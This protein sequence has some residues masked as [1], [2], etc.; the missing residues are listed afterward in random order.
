[1]YANVAS[2]AWFESGNPDGVGRPGVKPDQ[3]AN[4]RIVSRQPEWTYF[5]HRLHP[6]EAQLPKEAQGSRK[7]IKLEDFEVPLRVDGRAAGV[8][9]HLEFRPVVGAI[10][11]LLRSGGEP[12]AGVSVATL[13]GRF[14]GVYLRN[15]SRRT[16][17]VIGRDGEPFARVGPRGTYVNERSPLYVDTLRHKGKIARSVADSTAPAKWAIVSSASSFSWTEPRIRYG[18]EQPPDDIAGSAKPVKLLG[19][20]LPLRAGDR[21]VDVAGTTQWMP[22]DEQGL[23]RKSGGGSIAS[24]SL[25]MVAGL[26]IIGLAAGF[27]LRRRPSARLGA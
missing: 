24:F 26:A 9:G 11:P 16:V 25:V 6:R 2:P 3:K 21:E 19:W 18:P 13:P 8:K 7:K 14:P 20:T 17:T 23:P 15:S 22:V 12:F 27:R 5:E 1:V 10:Q 4:W